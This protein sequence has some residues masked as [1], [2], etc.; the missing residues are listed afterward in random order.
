MGSSNQL[1]HYSNQWSVVEDGRFQN[2][3]CQTRLTSMVR[4]SRQHWTSLQR[5]VF[6]EGRM[7]SK[8]PQ[9][10]RGN[11]CTLVYI[12]LPWCFFCSAWRCVDPEDD[13]KATSGHRSSPIKVHCYTLTSILIE[14]FSFTMAYVDPDIAGKR[15][16]EPNTLL[17]SWHLPGDDELILPIVTSIVEMTI[18]SIVNAGIAGL[19]DS[20][21]KIWGLWGC[22]E[23]PDG[24]GGPCARNVTPIFDNNTAARWVTVAM[25]SSNPT[26]MCL[27]YCS[28]Q[29]DTTAGA[30]THMRG[31]RSYI[32]LDDIL[33]AAAEDMIDNIGEQSDDDGETWR[34]KPRS[35]PTTKTGFKNFEWTV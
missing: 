1:W 26:P 18:L 22:R 19:P 6:A 23:E 31:G 25:N 30:Q 28:Q 33:H 12:S 13:E 21:Q 17:F 3:T 10:R 4:N 5:L 9:L 32:P 16:D 7:G 35:F 15:V 20:S 2:G 8:K 27:V 24:D 34:L 14:P 11:S 29:A